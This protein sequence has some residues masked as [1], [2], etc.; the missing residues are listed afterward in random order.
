MD[1]IW[2]P[3]T[4]IFVAIQVW[5]YPHCVRP[6]LAWAG[7]RPAAFWL[8]AAACV[9]CAVAFVGMAYLGNVPHSFRG[10]YRPI[11][12]LTVVAFVVEVVA[13]FAPTWVVRLTGGPAPATLRRFLLDWVAG[14]WIKA[15][16]NERLEEA[17]AKM[18]TNYL[19][20]EN[21][22]EEAVAA[23]DPFVLL[24]WA[25]DHDRDRLPQYRM[26]IDAAIA[27]FESFDP[28]SLFRA[29]RRRRQ[30]ATPV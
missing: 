16:G 3:L 6:G 20:K 2:I 24:A 30:V 4:V 19:V 8:G 28:L 15:R 5:F 12:G 7:G 11:Q 23:N 22:I 10:W 29:S 25:F 21:L 18:F 17:V 14:F 27:S 26:A 13:F 9:V 1:A